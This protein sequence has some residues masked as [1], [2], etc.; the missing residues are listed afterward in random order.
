M[1][2]NEQQRG[3]KMVLFFSRFS[4]ILRRQQGLLPPRGALV[5]HAALFLQSGVDFLLLK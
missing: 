5:Q 2:K 4:F 1:G 3:Q